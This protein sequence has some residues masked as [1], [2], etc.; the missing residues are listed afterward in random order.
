[1]TS[2]RRAICACGKDSSCKELTKRYKKIYDLRGH[3]YQ[4]PTITT[5]LTQPKRLEKL[6][7]KLERIKIHLDLGPKFLGSIDYMNQ[8]SNQLV[9]TRA[10][11]KETT[12]Q[13]KYIALHHFDPIILREFG[14]N[15]DTVP[16]NLIQNHAL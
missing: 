12:R 15:I 1:M 16:I 14:H 2:Y 4:I 10:K 5:G 8:K 13:L 9:E 6:K 11:K 7:K 3:Y